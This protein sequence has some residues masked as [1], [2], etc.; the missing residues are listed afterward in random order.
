MLGR[1]Q[2][3]SEWLGTGPTAG[4]YDSHLAQLRA[5]PANARMFPDHLTFDGW[6]AHFHAARDRFDARHGFKPHGAG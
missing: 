6:R 2:L 3:Y 5:T 1:H 4:V